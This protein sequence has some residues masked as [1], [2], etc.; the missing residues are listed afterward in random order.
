[1]QDEDSAEQGHRAA[2]VIRFN[3]LCLLCDLP[4]VFWWPRVISE[5]RQG[6]GHV[7]GRSSGRLS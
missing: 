7:G 1:M 3:G 5:C 2:R 6:S 4:E